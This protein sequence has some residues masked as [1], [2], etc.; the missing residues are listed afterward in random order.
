MG[1]CRGQ[2]TERTEGNGNV[3]AA[4]AEIQENPV[5]RHQVDTR[6]GVMENGEVILGSSRRKH[7]SQVV[8]DAEGQKIS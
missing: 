1:K 5:S 7:S 4:A 6:A 2:G 3:Q 8:A